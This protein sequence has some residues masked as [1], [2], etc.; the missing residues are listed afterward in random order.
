MALSGFLSLIA[1]L[2][3]P[4]RWSKHAK[5]NLRTTQNRLCE[6]SKYSFAC[7]ISYTIPQRRYQ[8]G[9]LTSDWSQVCSYSTSHRLRTFQPVNK[10]KQALLFSLVYLF[11]TLS[12]D[13]KIHHSKYGFTLTFFFFTLRRHARM[14]YSNFFMS[15]IDNFQQKIFDFFFLFL[16]KT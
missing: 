11:Q 14:I 3:I 6:L 7:R 15:K 10:I 8:H 2:K 16:L 5:V 4:C 13:R 1:I 9:P 12:L